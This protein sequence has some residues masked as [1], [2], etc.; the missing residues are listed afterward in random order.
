MPENLEH[1]DVEEE[2]H[3]Y[4]VI[5]SFMLK[6]SLLDKTG[7]K[8]EFQSATTPCAVAVRIYENLLQSLEEEVVG[9]AFSFEQP[10]DCLSCYVEHGCCKQRKL[11]IVMVERILRWLKENL[12]KL[13]DIDYC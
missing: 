4:D 9:A 10:V 3:L 8:T 2:L 11:M 7:M 1:F 13:Q 12:D 5:T 6:A